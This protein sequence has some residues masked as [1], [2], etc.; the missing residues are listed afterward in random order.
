MYRVKYTAT[1]ILNSKVGGGTKQRRLVLEI[2][3]RNP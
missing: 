1:Q 2:E 3:H